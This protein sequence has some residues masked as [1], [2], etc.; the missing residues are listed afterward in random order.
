MKSF[1]WIFYSGLIGISLF[2]I[3]NVYFI[4]PMPGS[5]E[6]KSLDIAYFL[7]SNRWIFRVCFS[8]MIATGAMNA[9][10]IKRKWL[11]AASLI[12]AITITYFFNFRMTAEKIFRQP[13]KL[14][15][16]GQTD[17]KLSLN[18]VVIGVANNGKTKGYPI[19]FL[20]YH[21]QVQDTV[22]GK[23]LLVTYCSVCRTGRVYEPL[24]KGHPEKFRLVG[25]DH[26]NAM[27]EDMTTRSWWRQVTG[28]A[29]TG[30]LKGE[31][32]PEVASEQLTIKKL[33]ELHPDALIMQA[34][35][36]SLTRYDSLR[37]FEQG[38]S[39]SSLTRTDSLSWK[40]KSWVIG[41]KIGSVEK[42]FDWNQLKNQHIINDNIG[43]KPFFLV[44]SNDSSSFAAFERPLETENFT[45]K[46]DTLISNGVAYDFAGHNLLS[47]SQDLK[48]VNAYQ[49]FWHSWKTFHPN[50]ERYQEPE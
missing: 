24:V 46:N 23:P 10:E 44:L 42:A 16:K 38:L 45:V 33:F 43:G 17:N 5:Q 7:Y 31:S 34:D 37:K 26:F 20:V 48:P 2:E 12:V 36:G 29:V 18:S 9:F 4:M 6:I 30:P 47:T 11:P 41:V 22:G 21:H 25:M 19:Q 32:L 40:N 13:G 8:I 39:R 27:F 49:E 15:F 35:G 14:I 28:E 50:T 3:L 1:K